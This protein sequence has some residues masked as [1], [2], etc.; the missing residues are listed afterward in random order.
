MKI[1]SLTWLNKL[2][3]SL[4]G[5]LLL[6]GLV[7]VT[8]AVLAQPAL[9]AACAVTPGSGTYPTI[10]AAINDSNCDPINIPAGSFAENL[11]IARSLTLQGAGKTST[12]INGSGANRVVTINGAG[13]VVYINDLRITGGN[14]TSAASNP[15][16]GGGILVAGGAT[17]HAENL[18]IDDNAASTGS[19][20]GF[21]GGLAVRDGS[22]YM[23]STMILLN[24]A[25]GGGTA[26][27]HQGQGGGLY[28]AGNLGAGRAILSLVDS[29]VTTN[30]A[31]N[32]ASTARGAG[33]GLYVGESPNTQVYLSGNTWQ[34]NIARSSAANT[35]DG[36]GGAVAIVTLNATASA[37][38]ANDTFTG[39]TA[40]ASNS[41]ISTNSASGGAIFIDTNAVVSGHNI[42]ATLTNITMLNNT[43]KAGTGDAVGQGGGLYAAESSLNF[44]RG[45]IQG[46]IAAVTGSGQGGGIRLS[47]G[48]MVANRL[49][50]LD[51]VV[52]QSGGAATFLEGGGIQASGAGSDLTL[53]NSILAGNTASSGNGAGLFINYAGVGQN[54]VAKIGHVTVA[55]DT[56]N[57][58]EGIYYTGSAGDRLFIT[59]TIV[60]S[61]TTGIHNQGATGT[62][63]EN[64]SLFFGNTS[65]TVGSVVGN[66]G[67]ST[68]NPLFVNP[69]GNDYH[70]LTGSPAINAGTNAGISDDID[71]GARDA[72]PDLGADEQGVG[73]PTF[74]YLPNI[75]K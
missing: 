21:G 33:G 62:V 23:T 5:S 49:T 13:L 42:T 39:N 20:S 52:R 2:I 72:Q 24:V 70:L 28:A 61:H 7:T 67:S 46:N 44:Q 40:N 10:Q 31:Y 55:D 51:N 71:G 41:T 25:K 43:A 56:L 38:L 16:F 18:Q 22:A 53:T 68:G 47:G 73:P 69:A 34:G 11:N 59:N 37:T 3:I 29:Q 32:V 57:G 26:T 4:S 14:A 30:T 9:A 54:E 50:I 17:L 64:Y 12:I 15:G 60:A 65:N 19:S 58:D 66:V 36:E 75:V 35:G 8:L 48:P 27:T 6:I 45:L 63:Q 1:L 74:V